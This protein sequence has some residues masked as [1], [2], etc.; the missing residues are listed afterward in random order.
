MPQRTTPQ[1]GSISVRNESAQIRIG[2]VSARCAQLVPER[3]RAAEPSYLIRGNSRFRVW[4]PFLLRVS[5]CDVRCVAI[6]RLHHA[7]DTTVLVLA[8][9]FVQLGSCPAAPLQRGQ[10]RELL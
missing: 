9:R 6:A 4:A 2:S 1:T 3:T 7:L 8:R 10:W 5:S